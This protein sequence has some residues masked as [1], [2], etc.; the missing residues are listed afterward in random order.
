[1]RARHGAAEGAYGCVT[2]QSSQK[3]PSRSK[4]EVSDLNMIHSV[5]EW[6]VQTGSKTGGQRG[7]HCN[8]HQYGREGYLFP[9]QEADVGLAC[10]ST[11]SSPI[12]ILF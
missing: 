5:E 7:Q 8:N 6:I 10:L 3:L 2:G 12:S 11:D 4:T 9:S 1:M